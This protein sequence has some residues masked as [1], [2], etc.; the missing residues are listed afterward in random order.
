M[1]TEPAGL[2]AAIED[3]RRARQQVALQQVLARLTGRSL[4]LLSYDDVAR[5][6]KAIG[7][8]ERGIQ[9]I[10]LDA[11]A[12][13]VGRP[14]DFTRDFLPLQ[15]SDQN[16]WARVRAAVTDPSAGGLPP[17]EV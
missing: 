10:P 11:I 2:M 8:T 1:L 15:D 9:D 16:R 12:G 7:R 14:N 17:I 3:F 5:Q 6:L 13:S 4:E